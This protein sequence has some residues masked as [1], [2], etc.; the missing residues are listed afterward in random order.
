MCFLKEPGPEQRVAPAAGPGGSWPPS[1]GHGAREDQ[2]SRREAGGLRRSA[3]SRATGLVAGSAVVGSSTVTAASFN[4][5]F[6]ALLSRCSAALF[7]SAL[8]DMRMSPRSAGDCRLRKASNG[9]GAARGPPPQ[10]KRDVVE[11]TRPLENGS[12]K[13]RPHCALLIPCLAPRP[14]RAPHSIHSHQGELPRRGSQCANHASSAPARGAGRGRR[15]DTEIKLDGQAPTLWAIPFE[16]F[17]SARPHGPSSRGLASPSE[18]TPRCVLLPGGSRC[19]RGALVHRRARSHGAHG[20]RRP[21]RRDG[22][23]WP[24]RAGRP[25]RRRRADWP[26][27]P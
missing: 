9:A 23:P 26:R 15:S 17:P 22:R 16:R 20:A 27:R 2:R 3:R 4:A 10:L 14:Q 24:R 21:H 18:P 19:D 1:G 6:L 13:C 25:H 12:V 8:V 11:H 7:S 5:R